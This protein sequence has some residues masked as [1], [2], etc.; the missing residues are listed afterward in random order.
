MWHLWR[1]YLELHSISSVQNN[2]H[3]KPALPIC[4]QISAPMSRTHII[5]LLLIAKLTKAGAPRTVL[6][7]CLFYVPLLPLSCLYMDLCL[8]KG[9]R[10]TKRSH[11][12]CVFWTA[13]CLKFIRG[14]QMA[15]RWER[16]R[17][18][19]GVGIIFLCLCLFGHICSQTLAQTT[20]NCW[21]LEKGQRKI[22]A[23][24]I[25]ISP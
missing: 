21:R 17:G 20:K 19:E 10:K 14:Q 22:R 3:P 18:K 2:I 7:I 13:L 6:S 25:K 4:S 15:N 9:A 24:E 5:R 16:E 23:H 8:K 12:L 11:D 1:D